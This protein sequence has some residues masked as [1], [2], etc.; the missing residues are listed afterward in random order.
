MLRES[1]K[2]TSEIVARA[3][4]A[5]RALAN[6]LGSDP[7]VCEV[8]RLMRLPG[9]FNTKNG[10]RLPVTIIVDRPGRYE[11]SDLEEWLEIQRPLIPRK[12]TAPPSNPFLAVNI[13]GTGGASVD[14]DARLAAMRFKGPDNTC[15]H[16]TQ[17]A[18][19]A[20][21]LNRG[22]NVEQVVRTVL[23]STRR[24]AGERGERW[25]WDREERDVRAMCASWARKKAN[26]KDQPARKQLNAVTMETLGLREYKPME[27][28]VPDL[29][30]AE[31]VT[32]I[33]GRPKDH[34][35]FLLYDVCISAALGR[36]L[37][38]GRKPRHG[39]S[40]YLALEDGEGRLHRRGE[41]LLER[42]AGNWPANVSVATECDRVDAGGLDQIRD[43]VLAVRA[44][45]GAVV[46][47]A[48][49]VLMMIRPA[50]REKQQAY[51]RDYEAVQG[52]R[53]LAQEL[54]LAILVAHH[55]RKSAADDAQD[56]ISGTLGLA[57]AA[58]CNIV[59]A[60]QGDGS[61]VFDVRGRDVESQQL[62]ATFDKSTLR[63][64][65]TGDAAELRQ[66]ETRR[67]ILEA[68]SSIPEGMMPSEIAAETNLKPGTVR[69][70][71]LRMRR[72]GKVRKAGGK[73]IVTP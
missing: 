54:G 51:Q 8:A 49:D 67:L 38:G 11:L 37:L 56:T 32:L 72:D 6:V 1:E 63:W 42:H 18:V 44:T 4:K 10:D 7:A 3:E 17:L 61:F 62:A 9:S 2:A 65:V 12:G 35:S 55:T 45:G 69:A 30:P 71:L 50:G 20:A 13:P 64:A 15:I 14:V 31:G 52:L 16:A 43:W 58:D 68:L 70:A 48:V 57:A 60:R 53:A 22:A 24:A 21:L 36:E 29:I 28:L 41:R 46:C 59:I 26:D 19:T 23:E 47:V 66:S 25:D 40:L 34:K 5:L 33:C 27:F 39:F 73:Y